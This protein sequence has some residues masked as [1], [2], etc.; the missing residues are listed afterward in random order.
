MVRREAR[1]LNQQHSGLFL[2]PTQ[3]AA[4]ALGRGAG[5]TV[6]SILQIKEKRAIGWRVLHVFKEPFRDELRVQGYLPDGALVLGS[7]DVEYPDRTDPI[8]VQRIPA[9]KLVEAAAGKR[10]HPR[11]PAAVRL[12]LITRRK[13]DFG[14]L[15]IVFGAP[16]ELR[17]LP[18]L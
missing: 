2:D 1:F 17:P 14:C 5:T 7:R 11:Y 16:V 13:Q 6:L 15:V 8:D 12:V 10:A 9:G 4:D 3:P 18:S